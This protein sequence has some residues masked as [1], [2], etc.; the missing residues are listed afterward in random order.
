VRISSFDI[1]SVLPA[2]SGPVYLGIRFSDKGNLPAAAL[3]SGGPLAELYGIFGH[4]HIRRVGIYEKTEKKCMINTER[5]V[6]MEQVLIIDN[7]PLTR[8]YLSDLLTRKGYDAISAADGL[9][10]L[11]VL[12]ESRPQVIF[13]DLIMPNIDG[14]TL[15][16]ILRRMPDHRD[17]YLVILSALAAEA[18][19]VT[20]QCGA[21]AVIAKGPFKTM[22]QAVLT[23]I[24][25]A[26]KQ[27][28]KGTRDDILGLEELHTREIS[29][30]LLSQKLHMELVLESLGEGILE[31]TREGRV[32]YGNPSAFSILGLPEERILASPLPDLFSEEERRTVEKLLLDDGNPLPAREAEIRIGERQV[33][34]RT[35]PFREPDGGTIVLFNDVTEHK[36]IE[37]MLLQAQRLESVGTLAA[38]VAHDFNNILMAIQANVSM[39]QLGVAV[40]HPY[41]KRLMEIEEQIRSAKRLTDQLLEYAR[42]GRYEVKAFDLNDLVR[43]IVETF[44]RTRKEIDVIIDLSPGLA[45]IE[46]NPNQIEQLLLNLLLNAGDAMPAGGRLTMETRTITHADVSAKSFTPRPGLYDVLTVRDTGVGM[47]AETLDRIFEPFFTTKEMGRGRGLGLASAYGIVKGHGGHI[48]AESEPGEGTVFRVYLPA[49]VLTS[50]EGVAEK[51]ALK[52]RRRECILLIEDEGIIRLATRDMIDALGFDVLTAG[53]GKEALSLFAEH[54]GRISLVILDIV[55][56]GMGGGQVFRKLIETDPAVKILLCTGYGID[57]EV[58]GLLD[59]GAVGLIQKPFSLERLSE[60]IDGILG[61]SE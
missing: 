7:H 52:E 45:A 9:S 40:T 19:E 29:R 58:R 23:I 50:L 21:N 16:R 1:F 12:R 28:F 51:S 27:G 38:G 30:E 42:G 11:G 46:G 3:P 41:H 25:E 15:C 26:R 4:R 8:E 54:K 49:V 18:P 32:I 5:R 24:D 56:P 43:R 14:I 60:I 36:R 59:L 55:M 61:K 34:V 13:V 2:V 10:A 44:G 17:S 37:A 47:N 53:T 48:E 57:E 35:Y 39:I 6:L 22:G 31:I 33:V 20:V